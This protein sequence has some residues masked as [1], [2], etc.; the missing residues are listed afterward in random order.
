MATVFWNMREV[1]LVEFQEH[2][3]NVNA[4]SYCSVLE[5][6]KTA[7][8]TKRKGLLTQWVILLHDNARPHTARRTLETLEQ[9]GVEV[10][11]HLPYSRDL[12]PRDWFWAD[13]I[14]AMWAEILIGYRGA[15]IVAWTAASIVLCS[16]KDGTNVWTNLD[17]MLKNETIMFN[18]YIGNFNLLS[19]VVF[20]SFLCCLWL[21][22]Y[23]GKLLEKIIHR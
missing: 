18:I 3:R 9:L 19:L 22:S 6:L 21:V 12:A 16:M 17:N 8:Q 5:Q 10:L 15:V 14:N 4:S 23:D 20:S 1:L 13:E 11:P 2:S 7:I